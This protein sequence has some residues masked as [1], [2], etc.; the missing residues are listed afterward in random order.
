L[1]G[2]YQAL[3]RVLLKLSNLTNLE[4][5]PRAPNELLRV[6]ASSESIADQQRQSST[7]G[8]L[9]QLRSLSFAGNTVI[10]D[11]G[12]QL[13][14]GSCQ[15]SSGSHSGAASAS[16]SASQPSSGSCTCFLHRV[17]DLSL[18]GCRQLSDRGLSTLLAHM[19]SL[20]HA[21]LSHV[22]GARAASMHALARH[23]PLLTRLALAGARGINDDALRALAGIGAGAG[24][25][26]A[27]S[28][29]AAGGPGSPHATSGLSL[30]LVNLHTLDLEDCWNVTGQGLQYLLKGCHQL[31]VLN[32]AGAY[33]A[34]TDASLLALA[35]SRAG[36]H[37]LQ[38][39][40]CAG[41]PL[42]DQGIGLLLRGAQPWSDGGSMSGG[43]GLQTLR[44]LRVSLLGRMGPSASELSDAGLAHIAASRAAY[45]LT[46]LDLTACAMLTNHTVGLLAQAC[47]Q[48]QHLSLNRQ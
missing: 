38:E 16:S 12:I 37:T 31:R 3:T 18:R 5:G 7:F 36:R 27:G 17:V 26:V 41:C 23:C 28:S 32:L 29:A 15:G 8:Y 35:K 33:N 30:G 14:V 45:T 47:E 34:V 21:D 9:T 10:T 4:I 22:S 43:V 2:D 44:S 19:P 11:E 1:P 20:R 24:A 46:A 13:L 42:T 48:M 25:A 39:L 40:N 6:L